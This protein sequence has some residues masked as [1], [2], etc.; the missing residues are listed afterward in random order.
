M[1]RFDW[2]ANLVPEAGLALLDG[3][4]LE[5]PGFHLIPASQADLLRRAGRIDDAVARYREAI[6]MAPTSEERAQLQRR[7][8]EIG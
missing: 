3:V 4:A 8:D 1:S 7:L 6:P 5:L 2:R